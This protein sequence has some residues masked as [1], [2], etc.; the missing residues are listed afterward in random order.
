VAQ[1]RANLRQRRKLLLKAAEWHGLE[2]IVSKRQASPYVSGPSRDWVKVKTTAWREAN[3][4]RWRLFE[5]R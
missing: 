4:E 3:R 1:R 2:G 5:K